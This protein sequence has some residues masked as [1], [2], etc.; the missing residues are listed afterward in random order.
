MIHMNDKL[1][2]IL[3][4]LTLGG[5]DSDSGS[6]NNDETV[7]SAPTI[8]STALLTSTVSLAYSY[9]LTATD[10]DNDAITLSATALPT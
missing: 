3:I 1:A 5:C 7:N 6:S 2:L 4:A 10:A 9:N 8:T